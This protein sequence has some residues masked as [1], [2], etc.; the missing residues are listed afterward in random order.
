MEIIYNLQIFQ[1]TE[2]SKNS[3]FPFYAL[4]KSFRVGSSSSRSSRRRRQ[5]FRHE[6]E[7]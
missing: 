6:F 3:L 2:I 4:S 1:R 7:E 5:L